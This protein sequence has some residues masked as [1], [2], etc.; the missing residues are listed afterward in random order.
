MCPL[1]EKVTLFL[2]HGFNC[3]ANLIL[4][5]KKA[6]C[7]PKQASWVWYKRLRVFFGTIGFIPTVSDSCVF[8]CP[9][10]PSKLAT[11][12]FAHVGDIIVISQDPLVF[13]PEIK[14]EFAIKYL[15][16]AEFLL[17]LCE[18]GPLQWQQDTRKWG[19]TQ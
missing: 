6:T 12:L 8:H 18:P 19:D 13:K 10:Q 17:G 7:G 1:E 15:G 2:P 16:K 3:P 11:W 5:L 14:A 9:S 4:E